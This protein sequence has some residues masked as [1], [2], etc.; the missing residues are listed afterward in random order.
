[1]S[2][3][4]GPPPPD[5]GEAVDLRVRRAAGR[6]RPR[7]LP[8]QVLPGVHDLHPVRRGRRL[9]LP[10]GPRLPATS[11][12]SASSRWR[13]S[14]TLLGGGFV[15]A[16]KVGRARLVGGPMELTPDNQ[17]PLRRDPRALS[18][19]ALGAAAR[20]PPRPGAGG[21]DQPRG[22]RVR[23][24]A[25]RPHARRRSTTP[26]ASTRCSGSSRRGRRSSRSARRSPAPSAGRRSC[27]S[28]PAGSSGSSRAR[29]RADGKFTV[30]R[31]R[32]PGRLR[33]R[34]RGAGERRV[35]RARHRGGHRHAC[36]PGETV[37]PHLRVAE[38]PG[39]A[40]SSSRTSGRRTRPRSTSTRRAG[41]YAKLG[42]WLRMRARGRS[43]RRS[44]SRT[45]AAAA[46]P[47]SRPG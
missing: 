5:A 31:R 13:S 12:C 41:G 20:A 1:M 8:D 16:W 33:R 18:G 37:R 39:R 14:S 29:R 9:P 3:L 36:S 2:H 17:G 42:E 26:P 34:P 6:D 46:A 25:P 27:S 44:R 38:E 35:A 24:V 11:A 47:A 7:A 32:V 30:K 23:G 4:L 15:Y 22:D 45:C 28:T 40:R 43:S 19:Q 10:V 21:L